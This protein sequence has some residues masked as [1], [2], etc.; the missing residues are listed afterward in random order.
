MILQPTIGYYPFLPDILV[1]VII[2]L[3]EGILK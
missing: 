3:L 2:H 1:R